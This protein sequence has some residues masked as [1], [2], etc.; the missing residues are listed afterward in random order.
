MKGAGLK[1]VLLTIYGPN[2]VEH[3]LSVKAVSRAFSIGVCPYHEV[4]EEDHPN[5]YKHAEI[6]KIMKID[7]SEDVSKYFF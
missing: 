5:R 4:A 2:A 7:L 6:Q 3:V 1:E